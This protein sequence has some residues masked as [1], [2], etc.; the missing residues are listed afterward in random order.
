MLLRFRISKKIGLKLLN[1]AGIGTNV[2]KL[3]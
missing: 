3:G 2:V 1:L